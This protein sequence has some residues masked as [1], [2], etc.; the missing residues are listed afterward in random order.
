MVRGLEEF[1]KLQ[2]QRKRGAVVAGRVSAKVWQPP[3]APV[4][5]VNVDVALA[6]KQVQEG[7]IFRDSNGEVV[8]ACN[9]P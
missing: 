7:A 3:P 5:K 1:R 8:A 9:T 2:E 6:E 4:I